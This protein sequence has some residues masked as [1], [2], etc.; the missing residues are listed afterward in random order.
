[1]TLHIYLAQDRLSSLARG[2]ALPDRTSGAALF[3]DISG[4][5]ALTEGLRNA[6]GPRRG[7]EELTRRIEA[8]Y[9]ALIAQIE[10][11]GGSV[12]DF[13]GDSMLCWFDED[14]SQIADVES[15]DASS[16]PS[17]AHRAVACGVA[18]QRVM[19]A[20]AK[21][22]LLD[23][24][25]VELALKVAIASGPARRFVVGDPNIQF[26]DVLAGATVT[27]TATG[28][29]LA[30]KDEI[31]VDQST[32]DALPDMAIIEEWRS[33]SES[34]ERFAIIDTLTQPVETPSLSFLDIGDLPL[35][36]LRPWLHAP[37]YEREQTAQ[38]SFL[39][40][41]RPCVTLFIRFTGIDFDAD[42]AGS[43]LNTFV[44]EAQR[45]AVR[46]GG[47]L[48][49]ITI[50]DKGSYIYINF[51]VLSA[52]ENDARRAVNAAL[53]LRQTVQA[54]DFLQSLQMGITQGILRI[55]AYGGP[56]RKTFG[57]LGDEVNLAARLMTTAAVNEILVSSHV[58][59]ALEGHFVFEPRP[60]LFMKGKAEPVP[61]FTVTSKRR[62]RAI[63][64]QEP[65]YAQP[66]VGRATELKIIEAKLN[67]ALSGKAQIIGIVA[68]AGLE[69]SRL[70]A[71]VIRLAH[72][73]GF[74]GFGGACQSDE[75]IR[76]I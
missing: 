40:E 31:L 75:S 19:R 12:I 24:S 60:P 48:L 57:A 7:A 55:G 9:S 66:M 70:V 49:D 16:Q 46:H 21:I 10:L 44:Q 63:R 71:E 43:Q 30:Q 69:K 39:T 45:T 33:D 73:K 52:H 74:A 22:T 47:T 11:F 54:M 25:S 18:L 14:L 4:F 37:V 50:G 1:M 15:L 28:E 51:G 8:V 27:R 3:A 32:I 42:E 58:Y 5:T 72:K 6:L 38:G 13:A 41:F 34:G 62:Q 17:A 67:L 64:L 65:N 29:H 23:D 59:K 53:E 2:E 68:E 20:H 36:A 26:I 76:R 56:T 35:T 61:V